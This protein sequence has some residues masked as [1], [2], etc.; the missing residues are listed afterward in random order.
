MIGQ[1]ISHYRI[2]EKIGEGGMGEVYLAEDI[3]LH[4]KV[5]VKFL[6]G[7][8]TSDP[9]VL[10]RFRRE[11]QAAAAL[12]HPNIITI[13]EVAEHG[14]RPFIVMAHV[15]GDA[16]SARISQG[17]LPLDKVLDYAVQTADGLARAH[18]TGVVHRDLKPDNVLIDRDD[19]VKILDFGLAKL[20]G[21][22]KLTR[23]SSTLG[24]VYYMSPEQ[25]RSSDVDH[26]SD[27]FSLGVMLYEMITGQLPFQG[28]HAA[29]VAHSI[30][31][32]EP[33]PLARFNGQASPELQRIVSKALA[34]NPDE[35]YQSAIDLGA[36]LRRERRR[37]E[38][39][40]AAPT[41]AEAE[42]SRRRPAMKVLIPASLVFLVV[43]ATLLLKPFRFEVAPDHPVVAAENTLAVMY[44]DNLVNS[45]DEKRTGEIITN[46]LIT[47]LSESAELNVVSSQRL[48]DLLKLEGKEGIKS[49]DH[50]T[51]TG[52]ARKAGA[53]WML[54]GSILQVEP[55][56]IVTSQ[57]VE[58]ADGRVVSSQRV[59]A[60][61][62]ENVFS[63]ADRISIEVKRDLSIGDAA[64]SVPGSLALQ[65]T[66]SEEAY[67]YYLEGVEYENKL[68]RDKAKESFL[69]ALE[70]DSTFA[71]AYY[72]LAL[73]SAHTDRVEKIE[74]VNKALRFSMGIPDRD[75]MLIEQ[76]HANL[77][78]K[79]D[80]AIEILGRMVERFPEDKTAHF[81][82]GSMKQR[83][84]PEAA[85]EHF[86]RAIEID[87]LYRGAYNRLAYTYDRLGDLEQSIW[88][89][90][91][92]IEIA[93]DEPNPYD[94][95]GDLYTNNGKIDEAMASYKKALEKKP[96]FGYSLVKTGHLHRARRDYA[97]A[98]SYYRR[99]LNGGPEERSR[100]RLYL[101]CLTL[102]Q[103]KLALGLEQLEQGLAAD[104]IDN[105]RGEDYYDK[106]LLK[107]YVHELQGEPGK[108]VAASAQIPR[109]ETGSKD[110]WDDAHCEVLARTGD[111][112]AAR[113]TA[114][115]I[116][117]AVDRGF[118]A[119]TEYRFALGW[120]AFVEGSY[121]EAARHFREVAE[122]HPD[123]WNRFPL[124]LSYLE[125]GRLAEAIDTFDEI[126]QRYDYSWAITP[127]RAAM[128]HYYA[129]VA[130]E[131]SGWNDRAIERYEEFL[132][133]WKDAD[134]GLDIV[135][136]S[137][138][139]LE[140]L[141]QGL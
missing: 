70:Y 54:L 59:V 76:L 96:D 135:E 42:S 26:R 77:H 124:A 78:G 126:L 51:S 5:A 63:V 68:I 12:S 99:L 33:H 57:I 9:D 100:A 45:R 7:A 129:G 40:L 97:T 89:I 28:D 123:F 79:Q 120:I 137:R 53:R 13:H 4:R 67:R 90:N 30:A 132:T 85:I 25:A 116:R 21:K 88:A 102:Y 105:T 24:T 35:R 52:V 29:A 39:F 127:M 15:E 19:H 37:T 108:A 20:R 74:Y 86:R 114:D 109:Y 104:R 3:A 103:G 64:A 46:L 125:D 2:L 66:E 72:E 118:A 107:S 139:R 31:T 110:G 34:K 112:E 122:L 27:I 10:T 95:R 134:P 61:Q 62:G 18:E 82:L 38:S 75:R 6:P 65:S 73:P 69:N 92:Y 128:M 94:T 8:Y 84:E 11:A 16:L 115:A 49:L 81:I 14:G 111:L 36:D 32:C 113:R 17:P 101:A 117:Q 98:E 121:G 93:P 119:E 41:S 141:R 55:V 133:I 138:R 83:E 106:L 58:I 131:R 43:L 44:F 136:D 56:M 71:L 130:Y 140:R 87:P 1:T 60:Q 47:N 80:K 48:Y 91:K 22:T 23:E 50:R